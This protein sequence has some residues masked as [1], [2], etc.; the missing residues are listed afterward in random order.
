MTLIVNKQNLTALKNHFDKFSKDGRGEIDSASVRASLEAFSKDFYKDLQTLRNGDEEKNIIAKD[1]SINEFSKEYFN[2]DATTL[3]RAM[4]VS[5]EN[6]FEKASE[7]LGYGANMNVAKFISTINNYSAM[8]YAGTPQ[9]TGDFD[10]NMRFLLPEII[11]QAIQLGLNY[12]PKS[13]QWIAQRQSVRNRKVIVPYVKEVDSMPIEIEEG[14]DIPEGETSFGQKTVQVRKIARGLQITDELISEST[15]DIFT[16]FLRRFGVKLSI[17]KDLRALLTLINGDQ[18]DLSESAPIIGVN[19]TG[20]YTMTD[21][22]RV[23]ARFASLNQPITSAIMVED[24]AFEDLNADYSGRERKTIQEYLGNAVTTYE[25]MP[26]NNILFVNKDNGLIELVYRGVMTEMHRNPQKQANHL[27][28]STSVGYA[29]IMRS[30]A[31][32]LSKDRA[33]A[34]NKF[35]NSMDLAIYLSQEFKK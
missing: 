25:A 22:D 26:P 14:E 1:I 8:S 13:N 31:V 6:T 33:W 11:L 20:K 30:G 17:G 32:L 12:S 7:I 23:T 18:E 29:K 10:P 28:V 24:L 27:Y 16:L 2:A 3:L 9:N 21:I 5:I 34:S 15:I 19:T 35:P 4:G